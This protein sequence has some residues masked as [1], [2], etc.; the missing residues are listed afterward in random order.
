MTLNWSFLHF[1]AVSFEQYWMSRNRKLRGEYITT[2]QTFCQTV[3]KLSECYK[4]AE[5]CNK[6]SIQPKFRPSGILK[7]NFDATYVDTETTSGIIV[8]NSSGTIVKAWIGWIHRLIPFCSWSRSSPQA[9][10]LAKDLDI[11]NL[12]IEGDF[13]NVIN[14]IKGIIAAFNGK[15]NILLL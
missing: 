1:L 5:I 10:R 15:E 13:L 2:V 11:T 6:R 3:N 12:I 8:R 9:L 14:F 4:N 7:V